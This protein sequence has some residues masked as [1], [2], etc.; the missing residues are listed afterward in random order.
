MME[1][2]SIKAAEIAAALKINKASLSL[3]LNGKRELRIESIEK[4]M[5][6]LGIEL[7]LKKG[8]R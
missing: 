6:F 2:H 3:Y 8:K 1:Q 4:I 5:D 7:R